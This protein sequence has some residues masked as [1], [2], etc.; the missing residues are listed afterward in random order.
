M[1]KKKGLFSQGV[2]LMSVTPL[3]CGRKWHC[4]RKSDLSSEDNEQRHADRLAHKVFSRPDM[5]MRAG[6]TQ[7]VTEDITPSKDWRSRRRTTSMVSKDQ[8]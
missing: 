2:D 3:K 7:V 4:Q 5:K 6:Q 8:Q 1:D